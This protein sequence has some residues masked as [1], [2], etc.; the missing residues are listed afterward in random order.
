[1]KTKNHFNSN[2]FDGFTE[3]QKAELLKTGQPMDFSA[4]TCLF[5]AGDPGDCLFIIKRGHVT[6][7]ISSQNGQEIILNR[8]SDGEVF[9][10]IAMFDEGTR[11]TNAFVEK[12][13]ELIFITRDQ[14]IKFLDKH[15][16]LYHETIDLLCRRLR[17]CSDLLEDF[18]FHDTLKRLIYKLIVLSE[19]YDNMTNSLIEISQDDLGKMLGASREVVNRNLGLLQDRGLI[20]VQRKRIVVPDVMK[21]K[22]LMKG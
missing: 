18:L 7:S 3:K 14:Y 5:Q 4:R 15:P 22:T 11:T 8:L 6:F 10:E 19:K 21:L 17:W 13:S 16:K 12:G 20:I 9:G 1:M 2:L